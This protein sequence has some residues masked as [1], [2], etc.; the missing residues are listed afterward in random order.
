M[1]APSDLITHQGG[2]MRAA[3]LQQFGVSRRQL[4]AALRD[5]S[6]IRVRGGVFAASSTAPE[7]VAAAAHGGA[8]TCSAALRMHGIWTLVDDDALHVWLGASGRV[9][10]ADCECVSHWHAGQTPL[11]LAP[12]PEVLLHVY[13]CHG[14]EAFFTAL[15]SA[16]TQRKLGSLA[17]LRA[18][19]P[20]GAR[21]LVDIARRDAGSGLES[22]LRLRFHL[23]G[24]RL[25]CQVVIPTVGRVD[26]V[27]AGV[28]I[29]ETDGAEHHG[30]ANSR[31]RD[32][33]RDAAASALG[34]ETLRF[35]YVMVVHD[36]PRIVDA[37]RAAMV[38]AHRA[39]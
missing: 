3:R 2:I 21:W 39:S 10:H 36:W 27:I 12:L 37:V 17:P 6:I 35:D 34:Y 33:Q 38:R 16:L 29:L 1:L 23:L 13:R 11:G 31:H 18:R 20:A 5:G 19:L 9:H 15:E 22:L 7:V 25:D 26:F 14:V 24:I 8:L 4:N 30:G 28:L 32:L